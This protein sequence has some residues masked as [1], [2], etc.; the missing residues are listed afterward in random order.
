MRIYRRQNY[1]VIELPLVANPQERETVGVRQGDRIMYCTWCGIIS[2]SEAKK[3]G[4][5]VKLC[6][7]RIDSRDLDEGEYG[8]GCHTKHGVYLVTDVAIVC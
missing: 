2:R 5:P 3:I 1:R 4:K 7:S 8:H 6:I